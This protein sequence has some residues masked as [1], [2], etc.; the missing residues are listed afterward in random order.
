MYHCITSVVNS[1]KLHMLRHIMI[2]FLWLYVTFAH[3]QVIISF[4]W[5]LL[6]PIR[7]MYYMT[8]WVTGR[9]RN[10]CRTYVTVPLDKLGAKAVNLV[11]MI[12][13]GKHGHGH[14]HDS[15]LRSDESRHCHCARPQ[16]RSRSLTL[17]WHGAESSRTMH[18]MIGTAHV[19]M[20]N[21]TVKSVSYTKPH[22][23]LPRL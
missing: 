6:R 14:G 5:K 17:W 15:W 13:F 3:V 8:P 16:S 22:L 23:Q 7:A 1:F 20:H 9:Q 21:F 4:F 2:N 11:L 10:F 12:T 19:H 18:S